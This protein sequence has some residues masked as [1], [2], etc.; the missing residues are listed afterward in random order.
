M[1][2]LAKS[3]INYYKKK[4][5]VNLSSRRPQQPEISI[6]AE[7]FV[8]HYPLRQYSTVI[9]ICYHREE[10]CYH[11]VGRSSPHRFKDPVIWCDCVVIV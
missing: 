8:Q 5:L 10:R 4:I 6:K 9:K 7:L 11:T 1:N 2:I 3:K